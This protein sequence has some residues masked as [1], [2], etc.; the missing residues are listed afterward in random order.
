MLNPADARLANEYDEWPGLIGW[1]LFNASREVKRFNRRAYAIALRRAEPGLGPRRE[2]FIETEVLEVAPLPALID[3][4]GDPI[5][6][7]VMEREVR[8][9]EAELRKKRPRVLGR[10]RILEQRL[11]DRPSKSRQSWRSLVPRVD[12][13]ELERVPRARARLSRPLRRSVSKVPR[14]PT[15]RDIPGLEPP[16]FDLRERTSRRDVASGPEPDGSR[17]RIASR[18]TLRRRRKGEVR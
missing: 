8:K 7:Q 12:D 4:D 10:Q 13:P 17:P 3:G 14:W 9:E 16:A 18:S 1:Q 15:R 6:A 11:D 2:E 5:D